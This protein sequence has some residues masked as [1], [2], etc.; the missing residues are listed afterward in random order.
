LAGHG[1]GTATFKFYEDR[2]NLCPHLLRVIR[3]WAE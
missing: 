2:D 1:R 3:H